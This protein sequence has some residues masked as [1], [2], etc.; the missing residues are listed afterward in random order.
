M[1]LRPV[2]RTACVARSGPPVGCTA[3]RPACSVCV[4]ARGVVPVGAAR[5]RGR[6]LAYV[7]SYP[8]SHQ[9]AL[10]LR[11]YGMYAEGSDA[12]KWAVDRLAGQALRG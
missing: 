8:D 4:D 7:S 6:A 2:W 11:M 1:L 5:W 3:C 12:R 10:L 9:G